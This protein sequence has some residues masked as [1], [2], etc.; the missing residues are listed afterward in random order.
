VINTLADKV[1]DLDNC[2][3]VADVVAHFPAASRP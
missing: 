1:L 3:D 2:A